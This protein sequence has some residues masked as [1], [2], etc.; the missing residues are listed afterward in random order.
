MIANWIIAG[1]L[2]LAFIIVCQGTESALNMAIRTVLALAIFHIGGMGWMI[3][4]LI[5]LII[6]GASR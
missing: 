6:V 3:P 4:Y 5:L 2:Y 1:I